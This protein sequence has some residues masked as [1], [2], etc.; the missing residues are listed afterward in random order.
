MSVLKTAVQENLTIFFV[1][2]R[3]DANDPNNAAKEINYFK[4]LLATTRCTHMLLS[5]SLLASGLEHLG[6]RTGKVSSE[7]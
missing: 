2:G 3:A 7:Q 4:P 6:Y 1:G 5:D